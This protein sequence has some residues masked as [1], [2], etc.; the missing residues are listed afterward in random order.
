MMLI[1]IF[2]PRA[3]DAPGFYAVLLGLGKLDFSLI[4]Q[5]RQLNGLPGHPDV[6]TPEVITNTGSLGMG[7][8]KAKGMAIA[9][10]L[11]GKRINTFVLT[12]DGELQEGQ[13]WESL[14][15]AVHQKMGE[16]TVIVDHNKIQSDTWVRQ[17]NDLGDL[18]E[19]FVAFGWDIFRCDGHNLDVFSETLNTCRNITDRPKVIIAD[20]IKGYG[21][22]FMVCT[23]KTKTDTLY[24]YHSGAPD[25]ESYAKAVSELI[26][27]SNTQLTD[28]GAER[29]IRESNFVQPRSTPKASQRL[30]AAY[31]QALV[32]QAENTDNLVVLDADLILDCGLMRFKK[33][34]P[35]RFI[36]CGIAEQDMVTTAGGLALRGMLPIV[37]SF[38][39]FLSARAN[40]QFYNNSTEKTKIIYVGSLAGLLPSG[41]GHSHESV[42]NIA[43]LSAIPGLILLQ[44]CAEYEVELA[45]EFCVNGTEYS[46]YI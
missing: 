3:H 39:C 26:C 10:R 37:H 12:G 18:E 40:E 1:Y 41:P 14:S 31:S 8:S 28:M 20:T 36:E 25:D 7:V 19:K 17:V 42:R 32:T 34:Y 22:S 33:Q 23:G 4:H 38:S 9:H 11:K 16:I 46:S 21:V 24:R 29:L 44:P 6:A 30:I 43:A 15:S 13:F 45:V 27:A 5:L 2:L 35:E